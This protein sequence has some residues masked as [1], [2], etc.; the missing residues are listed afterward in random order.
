MPIY[1]KLFNTFL[2]SGITPKTWCKGTITPIF[3]SGADHGD[4]SNYHEICI[5][6]C[7]GKLFFSILNQRFLDHVIKSLD[8]LHKSQICL[9]A[10]NRIAVVVPVTGCFS[11][12]DLQISYN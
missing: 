10:N 12:R 3:K 7:L 2:K 8:I 4:P 6:S 1:L 11:K 5:S 9:L